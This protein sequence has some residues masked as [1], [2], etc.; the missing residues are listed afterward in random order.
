LVGVFIFLESSYIE[1][2]VDCAS[3]SSSEV[4][5][6]CIS[7]SNN[8]GFLT[9]SSLILDSILKLK[10][11]SDKLNIEDEEQEKLVK[12]ILAKTS[13]SDIDNISINKFFQ[14]LLEIIDPVI[15]NQKLWRILSELKKPLK[16]QLSNGNSI[17]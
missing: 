11:S 12:S 17:S 7:K 13:E 9:S 14:R 8:L 5:Q 1:S 6:Y 10:E 4:S 2:N 15:S 3:F 16:P